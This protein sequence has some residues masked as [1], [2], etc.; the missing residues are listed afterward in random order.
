MA[1]ECLGWQMASAALPMSVSWQ[2]LSTEL[3]GIGEK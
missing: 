2:W 1:N 3:A